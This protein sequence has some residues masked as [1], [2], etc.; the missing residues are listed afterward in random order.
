[1]TSDNLLDGISVIVP[2]YNSESIIPE[3]ITE[4]E[5]AITSVGV[6]F[7][8]VLVNDGSRDDSWETICS[9]CRSNNRVRGFNLSRNFGQ[10]NALLCG[11]RNANYNVIVTMDDDLQHP[12]IEIGHL[13]NRL[14]E[15][16]DVV[17]GV[18]RVQSHSWWRNLFS[19]LVKLFYAKMTGI[20]TIRDISAFRAFRTNLRHAFGQFTG[21]YIL[22]DVLLSWSTSRFSSVV[23]ERKPRKRGRSNYTIGRLINQ[24][25]ILLTGFSTAPLRLGIYTGFLFTMFGC[26]V[27]CWV[28]LRYFMRGSVPGFTFLASLT[29][30]FG[31]VQLFTLGILGEYLGRIF[32]RSLEM[33]TYVIRDY[34]GSS[35]DRT[36]CE[37]PR[38]LAK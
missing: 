29:S 24:T 9:I 26:L 3:L 12:P 13:L 31:G 25:M 8:V 38:S 27:L 36:R 19:V 1:M 33:P 21:P 23:V 2:V 17:Y 28:I 7:E 14:Q 15:G 22:L 5:K 4:I 16:Y 34:V 20:S 32:S 35:S 11:I 6:P 30:I 10:H 18:P 37:E